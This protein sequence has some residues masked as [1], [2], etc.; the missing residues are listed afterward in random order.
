MQLFA[1]SQYEG[2]HVAVDYDDYVL[3]DYN[4]LYAFEWA[5]GWHQR[6]QSWWCMP[7][8]ANVQAIA[9]DIFNENDVPFGANAGLSEPRSVTP[10]LRIN[11]DSG[12][13]D[14]DRLTS[15][16]DFLEGCDSSPHALRRPL[17]PRQQ[18]QLRNGRRGD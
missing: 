8:S 11:D 4:V 16:V 17:G 18:R 15:G 13:I 12:T 5:F 1:E 3:D 2:P 7:P 14:M 6:A 9:D 10:T